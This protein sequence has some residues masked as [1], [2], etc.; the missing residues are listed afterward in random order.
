MMSMFN[1]TGEAQVETKSVLRAL[2]RAL[3]G[4]LQRWTSEPT[5]DLLALDPDLAK[6]MHLPR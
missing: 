5:F 1:M 2:G 3:S 6:E 4:I